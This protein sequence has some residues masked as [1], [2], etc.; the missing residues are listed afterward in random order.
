MSRSSAFLCR[1]GGRDDKAWA[2]EV[3]GKALFGANLGAVL[4]ADEAGADLIAD[5]VGADRTLV[6][7]KFAKE[8]K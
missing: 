1:I 2:D 3:D 7:D 5:E 4:G 6:G 8:L